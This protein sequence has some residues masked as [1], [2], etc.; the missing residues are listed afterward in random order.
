MPITPQVKSIIN[1]QICETF[2]DLNSNKI[3]SYIFLLV[4][5]ISTIKFKM[6]TSVFLQ[7]ISKSLL[8][9]QSGLN[10]FT[11]AY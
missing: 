5:K 11:T 2:T 3:K 10:G 4:V 9:K 1:L 8:F 6:L 7:K